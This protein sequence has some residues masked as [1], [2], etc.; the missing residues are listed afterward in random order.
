MD[1]KGSDEGRT[2]CEEDGISHVKFWYVGQVVLDA[3][4]ERMD[5]MKWKY[6]I[7]TCSVG[8]WGVVIVY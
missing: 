7:P 5:G 2:E 3:N 6:F 8:N 1:C 4:E